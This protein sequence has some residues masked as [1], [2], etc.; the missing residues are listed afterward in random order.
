VSPVDVVL[1]VGLLLAAVT[2]YRQ[3]LIA[4]ALGLVGFLLGGALGMV[5]APAVVA[6]WTNPAAQAV[7]TLVGVVL[8]AAAG[9]LAL[10]AV[11]SWARDSVAWRPARVADAAFGSMLSV[12]GV[13]VL[14]WFLALALVAGSTSSLVGSVRDS[15]ILGAV[16]TVMPEGARGLF[17]DLRD[18][19]DTSVFPE[20]FAGFAIPELVPVEE[21]DGDLADSPVATAL[22][23]SV[24]RVS[25]R[26]AT[27]EEG[28]TGS[29]FV[30]APERVM[31]NAHVLTGVDAVVV[32]PGG[33]GTPLR[34]RVVLFDPS[35]DIAVLAVPGLS[36]RPLAWADEPL[37]RGADAMAVGYPGGGPFTVSSARVRGVL[38]AR[39]RDIYDEA[40]VSREIYALR[41]EVR[42]GN[43][44]GPLLT[45]E[46][47]VAGVV[48]AASSEDPSTGYALTA[49]QVRSAA[50]AGASS[51]VPVSTGRCA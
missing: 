35:L 44:G 14:A 18:A 30:V 36:A 22:R 20:V 15:R 6:S 7:A 33:T 47:T 42:P 26:S 4:G 2:G 5:L 21:P 28:F 3:G 16:D 17:T 19:F 11:G 1:V 43:S 25:S 46:G 10:G 8:C 23:G 32:R 38:D 27:C 41:T 9:Q 45:L 48:F 29:G 51:S 12:V 34:A 39:G 24:V 37:V 31:T 49:D 50:V 13:L 40:V